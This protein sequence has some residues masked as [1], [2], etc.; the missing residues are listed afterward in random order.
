VCKQYVFADDNAGNRAKQE[1]AATEQLRKG[2]YVALR[3]GLA[4][5]VTTDTTEKK[6]SSLIRDDASPRNPNAKPKRRKSAEGTSGSDLQFQKTPQPEEA[7]GRRLPVNEHERAWRRH[8]MA[9]NTV[10]PKAGENDAFRCG[11]GNRL[12]ELEIAPHTQQSG[13]YLHVKEEQSKGRKAGLYSGKIGWGAIG[14]MY[15]EKPLDRDHNAE[16]RV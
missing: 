7:Q 16:V 4:S 15:V 10:G 5:V 12:Y 2:D 14:R 9:N 8:T 13:G 6:R 3:T 1:A 11:S